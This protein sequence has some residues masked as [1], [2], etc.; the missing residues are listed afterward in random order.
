MLS[1]RA[2]MEVSMILVWMIEAKRSSASR[3]SGRC[4]IW[5]WLHH[6]LIFSFSI[7]R[8]PAG[9][10]EMGTHYDAGLCR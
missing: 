1:A 7:V 4:T 3:G 5:I 8:P 2:R 6:C 9:K 10:Q